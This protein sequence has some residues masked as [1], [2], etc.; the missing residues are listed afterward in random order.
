MDE[1]SIQKK[2]EKKLYKL[3]YFVLEDKQKEK[4]TQ[5][6]QKTFEVSSPSRLDSWHIMYCITLHF[7][8]STDY[9]FLHFTLNFHV[10]LS[11]SVNVVTQ[12]L[13]TVA[14]VQRDRNKYTQNMAQNEKVSYISTGNKT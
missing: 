2:K 11:I 6:G 7:T 12:I 3:L 8:W 13:D 4:G 9:G 10:S 1:Y 5:K 14:W